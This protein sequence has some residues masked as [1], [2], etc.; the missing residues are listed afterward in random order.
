MK[1]K[2]ANLFKKS[3]PTSKRVSAN[4]RNPLEE[5]SIKLVE[6]GK[7]GSINFGCSHNGN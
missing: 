2:A 5:L 1:S 4:D 7:C 6:H 3:S